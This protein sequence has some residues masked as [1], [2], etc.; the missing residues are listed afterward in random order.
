[1]PSAYQ[2]I[3]A[4]TQIS[5]QLKRLSG[6]FCSSSTAGTLTIYD[7][8]TSGTSTIIVNTFNLVAGTFYPLPVT[9][10]TGFYCVLGGTAAITL[11]TAPY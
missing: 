6:V 9:A 2:Q 5:P 3:S 10:D 8:A 7:S 1:M 4:T 11:F